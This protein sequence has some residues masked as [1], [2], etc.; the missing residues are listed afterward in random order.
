[1]SNQIGT[2][3]CWAKTKIGEN[4]K[5][6]KWDDAGDDKVHDTGECDDVRVTRSQ[7]RGNSDL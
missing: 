6:G 4:R 5:R 3:W 2:E 7:M 1:M